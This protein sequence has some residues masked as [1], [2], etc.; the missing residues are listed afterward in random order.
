VGLNY[1]KHAQEVGQPIPMYPVLFNK[2]NNTLNRHK[3]T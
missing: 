3:G 2:F 1:R